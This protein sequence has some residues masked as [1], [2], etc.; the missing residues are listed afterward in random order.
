MGYQNYGQHSIVTKEQ[1]Y[2]VGK[3][4]I[5]PVAVDSSVEVEQTDLLPIGNY[6]NKSSIIIVQAATRDEIDEKRTG[7]KCAK[8]GKNE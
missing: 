2:T 8:R 7:K 3:L 4:E 1:I 5:A 6:I